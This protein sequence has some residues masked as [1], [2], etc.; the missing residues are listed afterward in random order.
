MSFPPNVKADA[1][2]ACARH[3]CI[4]HR[5]RGTKIECHHIVADAAGG[6]DDFENCIPVCFDCHA[7]MKSYDFQH[8]KG[9]KY[10]ERE[11]REHRSRWYAKVAQAGAVPADAEHL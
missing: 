5:F 9:S 7:D 10:S 8:P 6:A 1:L 3:C 11:L 2:V 4:C